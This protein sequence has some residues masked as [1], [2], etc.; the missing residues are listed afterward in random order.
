MSSKPLSFSVLPWS[1]RKFDNECIIFSACGDIVAT[2]N[3][4][5]DALLIVALANEYDARLTRE[6]NES[7]LEPEPAWWR[8]WIRTRELF[9]EFIPFIV[10]LVVSLTLLL[11]LLSFGVRYAIH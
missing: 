8:I 3:R 10:L 6:D 5:E 4:V 1:V 2:C 9:V 11:V 7:Q